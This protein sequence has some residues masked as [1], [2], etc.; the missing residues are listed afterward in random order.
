[1]TTL[2]NS[3]RIFPVYSEMNGIKPGRFA[4]KIREKLDQ[5]PN[6]FTEYLP[7]EFL[8][9]FNLLT[10]QDTI[11]NIHYPAS[12][13]LKNQ[14]IHR[15]FFDRL[16]RVQLFSLMNKLNYQ[17]Q[18][19]PI[20]QTQQREIL[21]TLLK[22]LPFE[23]TTAQKKVIKQIIDDFHAGKPMLRLLQGDVGS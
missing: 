19:K 13:Q 16:L 5:I 14:A 17:S 9:T 6:F 8:S 18:I 3:G 20:S 12:H 4:K 21:K 10:V 2:Y 22:L 1:M 15:V 11:K 23:L 7:E